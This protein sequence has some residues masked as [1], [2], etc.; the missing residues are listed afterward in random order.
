MCLEILY[1][2]YMYENVF[3]IKWPTIL[4]MLQTKPNQSTLDY[5]MSSLPN[6]THEVLDGFAFTTLSTDSNAR[7]GANLTLPDRRG[8][9]ILSKIS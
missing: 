5:E 7:L 2:K 1:L 8:S 3:G 6:I 9:Y 4:D